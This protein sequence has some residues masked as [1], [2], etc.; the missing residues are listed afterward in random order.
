MVIIEH[1]T[2]RRG[3]GVIRAKDMPHLMKN[4]RIDVIIRMD[5]CYQVGVIGPNIGR[6]NINLELTRRRKS[7]LT[8]F[9]ADELDTETA[10]A[11]FSEAQRIICGSYPLTNR[12]P[13]C[14][15]N[16]CGCLFILQIRPS[17]LPL[18][19]RTMKIAIP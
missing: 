16:D 11:C 15:T 7:P 19:V 8:S 14:I 17:Q 4:Y 12:I 18:E 5:W 10:A 2:K 1:Y 6:I 13:N 3:S 9:H